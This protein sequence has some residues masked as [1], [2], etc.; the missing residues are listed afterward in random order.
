MNTSG[1]FKQKRFVRAA[2][3]GVISLVAPLG[4]FL[5]NLF[6]F[7][8][9][10]CQSVLLYAYMIG[11]SCLAFGLF[12]YIIGSK[13]DES[14]RLSL[15]DHNT[16]IFNARY[17]H[18]RMAQEFGTALRNDFPLS[19]IFIDIDHFK[20]VNDRFGH[21]TGDLVLKTVAQEI[22][23]MVR[24]GDVTAR[25]GG[26][27][28]AV[29]LPNTDCDQAFATAER[30]RKRIKENPIVLP[31]R[32]TVSITISAG[33]ICRKLFPEHHVTELFELADKALFRA[34]NMGRDK[35]LIAE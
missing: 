24:T 32:E 22:T 35:V 23:A 8:D 6:V 10:R 3:G 21:P 4:W 19:L 29:L 1:P 14:L 25:V 15:L 28:F 13:E 16:G 2:Q 27:E 5:L 20:K 26:E 7:S 31:S 33:V 18:M 11:G 30:I 17:F 34:K 9:A 12:G